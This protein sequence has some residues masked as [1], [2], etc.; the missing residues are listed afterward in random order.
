MGGYNF[1]RVA[2]AILLASF[3][4]L[5]VSNVV[6]IVYVPDYG[7]PRGYSVD[8]PDS[9]S[10]SSVDGSSATVEVD[11]GDLISKADASKGKI[12]AKKCS[13]CH[14][15]TKGGGNRVGPNLWSIIGAKKCSSPGFS[16]SEALRSKG[17]NWSEE[18]LFEFLSN[19]RDYAKGTRMAFAGLS[20]PKDIADLLAYFKSL[21]KDGSS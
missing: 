15:L 19:P 11:I 7:S 12:I 8:V 6:D 9:Q 17:G 21:E 3:I 4:I 14:T 1:N 2:T 18:E 13:A 16:Y 10:G 20:K 5:V